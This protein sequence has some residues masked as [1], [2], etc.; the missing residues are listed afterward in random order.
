[1]ETYKTG[2][3]DLSKS[4]EYHEKRTFFNRRYAKGLCY[5]NALSVL[6]EIT[7]R[8]KE[9]KAA[10]VIGYVLSEDETK[11]VAVRHAWV[12]IYDRHSTEPL[13]V[14]VTMIADKTSIPTMLNCK[15]VEVEDFTYDEWFGLTVKNKLGNK[16]GSVS[17]HGIAALSLLGVS[18]LGLVFS[19]KSSFVSLITTLVLITAAVLFFTVSAAGAKAYSTF[20]AFGKGVSPQ[21][22]PFL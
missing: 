21:R 5:K 14:D 7:L 15:Y 2:R 13:I 12:K 1:M 17:A 4:I 10:G 8:E 9:V 6:S 20:H 22:L 16:I 18:A 11:K 3:I 19:K